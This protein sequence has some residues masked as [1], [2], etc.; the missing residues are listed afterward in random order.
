M[1]SNLVHHTTKQ[2]FCRQEPNLCLPCL[3]SLPDSASIYILSAMANVWLQVWGF[4]VVSD[5]YLRSEL[6]VLL[7]HVNRQTLFT[8]VNKS[9]ITLSDRANSQLLNYFFNIVN[10]ISYVFLP[11]MSK[12]LHAVLIRIC[13]AVQNLAYLPQ[14]SH[15]CW[16]ASLSLIVLI[17]TIWPP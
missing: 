4:G 6:R 12:S 14:H 1:G 3:S 2:S 5:Q 11:V 9:T 15:H 10:T 8:T 16:N 13:T 7:V 17:S